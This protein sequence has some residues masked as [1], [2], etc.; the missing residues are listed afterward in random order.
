MAGK[1]YDDTF[2]SEVQ[3]SIDINQK[4]FSLYYFIKGSRSIFKVKILVST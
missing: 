3:G 2:L 1:K 4:T